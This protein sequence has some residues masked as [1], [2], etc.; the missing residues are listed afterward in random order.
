MKTSFY[1]LSAKSA[2]G[3]AINFSDFKGKTVLIV[4]TATKCGLAPQFK[5]LEELH[6]K[7]KND[8]LVVIGFPCNQ[9]MG[10]EPETNKSVEEYCE[11]NFGVTFQ[12][13][14]KV[15]VNGFNTHPVFKYLKKSLGGFFGDSIKWNFTKFLIDKEGNSIKRYAPT[16][17]PDKIEKD[18]KKIIN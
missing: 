2:K 13:T 1:N 14:E 4:N 5:T 6:Q 17:T 7:Y 3:T 10:Q 15:N 11:I 12:L 18:I 8:G 9:F 16:D